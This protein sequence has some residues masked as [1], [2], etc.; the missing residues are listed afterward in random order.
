MFGGGDTITG[1]NSGTT[2]TIID[3]L[4]ASTGYGLATRIT[5]TVTGGTNSNLNDTIDNGSGV[6]ASVI[7]GP[8]DEIGNAVEDNQDINITASRDAIPTKI[9]LQLAAGSNH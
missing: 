8:I 6:T 3:L 2:A 7:D 5:Y 9:D 1:S 4:Q